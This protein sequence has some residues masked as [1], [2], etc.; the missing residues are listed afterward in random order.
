MADE[1]LPL[2]YAGAGSEQSI[3]TLMRKGKNERDFKRDYRN[4]KCI[5]DPATGEEGNL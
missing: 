2:L 1:I 5:S 3:I 4:S